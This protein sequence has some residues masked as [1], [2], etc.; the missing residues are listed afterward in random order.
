MATKIQ[1]RFGKL[2]LSTDGG[3]VYNDIAGIADITVNANGAEVK[4]TS[5]DDGPFETYLPGRNDFSMDVSAMYDASSAEQAAIIATRFASD[6]DTLFFKYMVKEAT[7]IY[8]L[9]CQGVITKCTLGSPNDDAT[10]FDFT[11]R[12]AGAPVWEAQA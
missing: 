5:H 12:L 8:A 2:K 6:Q 4:V 9:T 10:K 3:T 7:G 11:V 1:G